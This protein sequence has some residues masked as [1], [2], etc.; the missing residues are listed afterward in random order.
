MK[1]LPCGLSGPRGSA[2]RVDL[3]DRVLVAVHA[4]V[5]PGGED[6]LVERG[7]EPRRDLDAVGRTSALGFSAVV[8]MMPVSFT[9]HWIE[10]S[11]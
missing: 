3:V 11:W 1:A 8:F 5:E 6:V 4:H 2:D 7:V 10:P 9:S